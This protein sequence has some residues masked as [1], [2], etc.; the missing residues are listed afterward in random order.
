MKNPLFSLLKFSVVLA[1]AWY[2]VQVWIPGKVHPYPPDLRKFLTEV[3][4]L[5][6]TRM[7]VSVRGVPAVPK[8]MASDPKAQSSHHAQNPNFLSHEV[9]TTKMNRK[10]IWSCFSC[11]HESLREPDPTPLSDA[12]V[13]DFSQLICGIHQTWMTPVAALPSGD[14]DDWLRDPEA[15][16]GYPNAGS[17]GYSEHILVVEGSRLNWYASCL[18]CED[19]AVRQYLGNYSY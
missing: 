11:A 8:A 14:Q 10:W 15:R 13:T 9:W 1:I 16:L 12:P 18:A 4:E 19:Q 3:C 7:G 5:H 2:L 17:V 6:G